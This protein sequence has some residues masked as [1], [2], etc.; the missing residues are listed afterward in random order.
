M[1]SEKTTKDQDVKYKLKESADLDATISELSDDMSSVQTQLDAVSTFLG[2]LEHRCVATAETHAERRA[3]FLAE[4][5]GLKEALRV[6][7]EETAFVQKR[8][9]KRRVLRGLSA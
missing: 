8:S 7:R 1:K 4:I 3:R 2:K 9:I 5:A 6:L